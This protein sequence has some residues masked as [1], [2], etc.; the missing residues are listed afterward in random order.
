MRRR[1]V[2]FR[3][4]LS[5]MGSREETEELEEE[6]ERGE[7]ME[8][9]PEEEEIAMATGGLGALRYLAEGGRR[10][11]GE[12]S[13]FRVRLNSKKSGRRIGSFTFYD[14]PVA[15]TLCLPWRLLCVLMKHQWEGE[16]TEWLCNYH[17]QNQGG[18]C[19]RHKLT[20]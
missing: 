1:Q 5:E 12:R 18:M 14:E 15:E 8:L 17:C 13:R 10:V 6:G 20:G 2:V 4:R 9:E 3:R 7:P 11:C 16:A 19:Y